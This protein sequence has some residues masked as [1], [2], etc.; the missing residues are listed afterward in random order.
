MR[1]PGTGTGYNRISQDR[2]S[3]SSRRRRRE[4]WRPERWPGT[5]TVQQAKQD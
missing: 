1:W 2:S 4:G 3:S 5:G